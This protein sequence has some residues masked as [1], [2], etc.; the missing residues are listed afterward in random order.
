MTVKLYYKDS[1]MRRFTSRVLSCESCDGG[2][3]V[4]LAETAFFPEEGGQYS[5]TGT[6]GTARVSNVTERDGVIFHTVDSPL[7]VDAIVDGEI[8]FDARYEKM[9]CHTAE[10][11]LSG[12]ISSTYGL[13]NV[14]FHLGAE[15][16]TMD[17]SAP[18]SW[19]ELSV[20]ERRANEIVFE[21]VFR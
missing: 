9:Q 15:D 14:G 4:T 8:D 11:I 17:I 1:Y 18:L 13:H 5:D 6:L 2:Y 12:L 20:S 3:S 21:N 10:H 7:D 16:V 19:D